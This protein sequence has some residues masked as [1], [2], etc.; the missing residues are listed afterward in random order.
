MG[1]SLTS[2]GALLRLGLGFARMHVVP[3]S[4]VMVVLLAVVVVMMLVVVHVAAKTHVV[5]QA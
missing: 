2:S 4:M 5:K 3:V 1:G